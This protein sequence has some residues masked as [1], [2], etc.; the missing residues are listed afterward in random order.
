MRLALTLWCLPSLA[1]A[2][3]PA[4]LVPIPLSVSSVAH[5][6]RGHTMVGYTDGSFAD[7]GI[8]NTRGNVAFT[9][10]GTSGAQAMPIGSHYGWIAATS[11]VAAVTVLLPPNPQ[12]NDVARIGGPVQVNALTVQDAAGNP[13]VA[14]SCMP[15]LTQMAL[16]YTAPGGWALIVTP[17]SCTPVTSVFGQ[18][19]AVTAAQAAS[20]LAG[21]FDAAG[22]AATEATRAK[23]AEGGL[24]SASN[25]AGYITQAAIN[26]LGLGS[27]ATQPASAFYPASNPSGF[28]TAAQ[29]SSYTLPAATASVL[30][31]ITLS[32]IPAGYVL[33]PATSSV[34]GGVT[35]AQI[36]AA[37]TLPTATATTLGGIKSGLTFFNRTSS[38]ISVTLGAISVLAAGVLPSVDVTVPGVSAGDFVLAS[39]AATVPTGVTLSGV[40][41]T[42]ANTVRV[43]PVATGALSASSQSVSLNFAWMH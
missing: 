28:I 16:A 43:T 25:P 40:Q 6:A 5:D 26:A 18:T 34:L 20:A 35:L 1:F 11:A 23:A 37:Y 9:I 30:G 8:A 42:A 22:L 33:P 10:L 29:V 41:A 12:I 39:Y 38:P 15:G 21:A 2:A 32:Q 14:A 3:P 24:Y 27:A 19:G 7:D 36:P 13:V 31:G 4:N 17:S